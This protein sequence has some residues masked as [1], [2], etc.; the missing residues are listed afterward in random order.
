LHNPLQGDRLTS[1][2]WTLLQALT[3]RSHV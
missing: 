2:G 1:A 3:W